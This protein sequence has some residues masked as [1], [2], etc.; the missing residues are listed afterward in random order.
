VA[1]FPNVLLSVLPNHVF[2]MRLDP[3]APGV[4]TE[5][6]T[7]HLPPESIDVDETA[8]APTRKFWF[9]VNAEDID[10]VQRSQRGLTKGAPPPGPLIPRF[11]EPLHRFQNILA[12][13]MT[14]DSMA[15]IEVRA[16]DDPDSESDRLGTSA[17]PHPAAI[18]R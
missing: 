2:V 1:I 16:G 5:T 14:L 15:H 9:D 3:T 4:T 12:D 10:I 11:E 17:N 18:D 8:F 7:F 13:C 6:C